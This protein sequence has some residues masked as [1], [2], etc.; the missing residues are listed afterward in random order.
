MLAVPVGGAQRLL[1]AIDQQDP[2]GDAGQPVVQRLVAALPR[3][4]FDP[5]LVAQQDEAAQP[6]QQ[7]VDSEDD[8]RGELQALVVR[9]DL[10]QVLVHLQP[11]AYH[12]AH[13]L[14]GQR[15][16]AE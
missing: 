16:D 15:P 13:R 11:L 4:A 12:V 9:V 3:L 14:A 8:G 5:P 2:V 6:E 10:G 1:D 7:E